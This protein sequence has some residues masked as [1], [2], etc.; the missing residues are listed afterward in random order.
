M[1]EVERIRRKIARSVKVPPHEIVTGAF[2]RIVQK[3]LYSWIAREIGETVREEGLRHVADS[4]HAFG[5]AE[6]EVDAKLVWMEDL[7]CAGLNFDPLRFELFAEAI[8]RSLV[9][10]ADAGLISILRE[11]TSPDRL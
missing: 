5:T 9:R 4:P 10:E 1:S 8:G 11:D 6:H 3:G 7:C 2:Q